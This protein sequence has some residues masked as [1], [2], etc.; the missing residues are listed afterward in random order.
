MDK[1]HQLISKGKKQGYILFEEIDK[2]FKDNVDDGKDFD[3]FTNSI[4]V[5]GIKILYKRNM[6]SPKRKKSEIFKLGGL[7]RTTD[8]VKL[9][10][11][12]MGNISLLTRQENKYVSLWV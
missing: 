3:E 11:R 1:I 6:C 10:L 8:P 7:G 4:D 9:Y 2:T 12:E 5:Y